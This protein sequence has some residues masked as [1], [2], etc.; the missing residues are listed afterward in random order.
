MDSLTLVG[1]DGV[2]QA[3]VMAGVA[4]LSDD[5]VRMVDRIVVWQRRP[6]SI[7]RL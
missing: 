1:R 4:S 5:C 7:A 3:L 6:C 2:I